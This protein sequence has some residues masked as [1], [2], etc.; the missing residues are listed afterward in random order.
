MIGA[1]FAI[2]LGL[3][4]WEVKVYFNKLRLH[5]KF[6]GGIHFEINESIYGYFFNS[7]YVVIFR[8]SHKEMFRIDSRKIQNVAL[9][10][11]EIKSS[12]KSAE[13]VVVSWHQDNGEPKTFCFDITEPNSR[14]KADS[15]ISVL[16]CNPNA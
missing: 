5:K 4:M 2:L 16:K 12:R 3:A 7:F 9:G 6:N 8:K 11:D 14:E 13:V 15:L 1:V 10:S